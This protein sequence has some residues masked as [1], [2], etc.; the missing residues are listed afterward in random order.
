MNI[1]ERIIELQEG[2]EEAVYISSIFPDAEYMHYMGDI[3]LPF[4]TTDVCI[5]QYKQYEVVNHTIFIFY[6][7]SFKNSK[8]KIYPKHKNMSMN[9]PVRIFYLDYLQ[10]LTFDCVFF[11]KQLSHH[12]DKKII[13]EICV[14]TIEYIRKR[15]PCYNRL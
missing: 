8:I 12:L 2:I 3:N 15:P 13:N 4:W 14:K 6:E 7:L 9:Y 10:V 11:D 5:E 1:Q